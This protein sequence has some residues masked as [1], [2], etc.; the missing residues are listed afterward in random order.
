MAEQLTKKEQLERSN[1]MSPVQGTV[2]VNIPADVLWETFRRGNWWPRWNRCFFLVKNRDL[3]PGEQLIWAFDPIKPWFFYKMPAAAKIVEVVPGSK[4]TW[5]V[6]VLP[7]FYARHTYHMEDIGD[8][9]SRF[10]SWEQAMGWGFR[11]TKWFWVAHFVF[12]KDKSL[13]GARY[14][15]Q[16]YK[17]HGKIAPELLKPRRYWPF[18][19]TIILLLAILAGGIWFYRTYV[20]LTETEIAP[21]VVALFG[22]GGNSLLVHNG[23]DALLVDTKFPPVDGWM[24]SRI[25]GRA[26]PSKI[27]NTHYHYDHTQG[28]TLYPGAMI[29]AQSRVP[30]L[31]HQ[32][33]PMWWDED[34]A[35]VPK[36]LVDQTSVVDVGGQEVL[37]TFP[38][39][40]HTHGDLWVY[41]KRG[42][43]EIIATGDLVFNGFYPFMDPTAG[44]VDIP[45]IIR[46][47]RALAA[48]YPN[49]RFVPGHGPVSTAADVTRF[50]DFLQDLWDKV[51]QA[52]KEGLTEEQAASSIDLTRWGLRRLLSPHNGLCWATAKN[53]IRWVYRIQGGTVNPQQVPCSIWR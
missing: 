39:F 50:A 51:A 9:R 25:A 15:E 44:G 43:I 30:E 47:V 41:L 34:E 10:G 22:G 53:N 32:R 48:D 20:R 27:V 52:R 7:G 13:E 45:G 18:F 11:L 29:Y 26:S 46:T 2:D 42:D 37:L 12:V 6:V 49:A 35:G 16:V 1:D 17:T 38:G 31:M 23:N 28:N 24:R 36:Q 8:G 21:G 14:L 33:N 5:E 19:L 40:A 4:V 3:I